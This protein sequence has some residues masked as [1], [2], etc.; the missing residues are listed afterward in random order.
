VARTRVHSDDENDPR[1][2]FTDIPT[3]ESSDLSEQVMIPPLL[4]PHNI[5]VSSDIFSA[6]MGKPN[7]SLTLT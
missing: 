1:H 4:A 6:E 2:S 7:V 3:S 5:S